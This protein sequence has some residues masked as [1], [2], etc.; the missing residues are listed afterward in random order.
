MEE[1]EKKRSIASGLRWIES[2]DELAEAASRGFGRR[3]FFF[4]LSEEVEL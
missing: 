1:T 4:F 3:D 2:P